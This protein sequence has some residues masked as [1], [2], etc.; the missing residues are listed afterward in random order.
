MRFRKLKF[1]S[2]LLVLYTA[3]CDLE[4][5][6]PN[7]PDTE[8]VYIDQDDVLDLIGGSF[9]TFYYAL[10]AYGGPGPMLSTASFQHSTYAA[11]G[12]MVLYSSIPRNPI[13]NRPGAHFSD[14]LELVWY[15]AYR[16]IADATTGIRQLDSGRI[17]ISLN[18]NNAA[19]AFAKFTQGVA[20][21]YI[22]LLYDKGF[23]FD[24]SKS[25][26]VV[27][28]MRS[29]YELFE[30]ASDYL[31]TAILIGKE[32]PETMLSEEWTGGAISD[33]GELSRLAHSYRAYFR[34]NMPRT[35]VE[36]DFVD[37][38]AVIEDIENGMAE[39]F[40]PLADGHFSE[41][42]SWKLYYVNTPG[43]WSQMNY[44]IQG[45]ADQSERYQTWYGLHPY[46]KHP[47]LPGNVP[48]LIQT[49]DRRFPQGEEEEEQRENPGSYIRVGDQTTSWGRPDR[50]TWRWSYYHDNRYESYYTDAA[51]GSTPILTQ[52]V[53]QLIKA[54]ALF[55]MRN[56]EGAAAILNI[57]RETNGGLQ[58]VLPV[59]DPA[60]N[61]DCVPKLPDGSCGDLWEML[62]WEKRLES[63]HV[64]LGAWYFD[65]RRWGDHMEGTFLQLPVPGKELNVLKESIYTFG[66]VGGEWA[67]PIGTYGF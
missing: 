45:M 28:E 39:D 58:P 61:T 40:S 16:A 7:H 5:Q 9:N 50:G 32:H 56:Y 59:N 63:Y 42:F 47:I 66:G 31:E 34:A 26:H 54:E 44:F 18:E 33:L 48:F 21:G 8:R 24:E 14:N 64:G 38:H 30:A 23:I 17:A 62:K 13:D 52:P 19:R 41:W 1:L 6:N 37:W 65:S 49:P 60:M 2:I 22:A 25:P 3:G 67:A 4:I 51:G 43:P 46:Y 27:Y 20:H 15:R 12:G 11:G 29:S 53:L 57:T 36:A 10:T 35:P 55:R